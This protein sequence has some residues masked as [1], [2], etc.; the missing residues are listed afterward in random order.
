VL[1]Y[2]RHVSNSRPFHNVA[3]IGFMG[4]GKSSVGRM[5][6][7]QLR[8]EFVDTDELLEKRAGRKISEIFVQDGEA[9][10]REMER[11]LVAEM[12]SWR[13]KVIATGGGLAANEANLNQLKLHSLVVCLW[14]TPEEIWHRVRRQSHRP[15]LRDPNPLEKIR[16]LLTARKPYYVQADVLISSNNR[17]VREVSAHIMH[18]FDMIRRSDPRE[19]P[20]PTAR[21]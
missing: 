12:E 5:L 19:K 20:H 1:R 4:T 10:F 14:A 13:G 18:E 15:L 16:S 8:F 7:G 11:A 2:A 6:A 9:R 3:L 17:S 21:R